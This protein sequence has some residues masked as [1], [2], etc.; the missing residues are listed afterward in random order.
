M[1]MSRLSWLYF[2]YVVDPDK[3]FQAGLSTMSPRVLQLFG[4]ADQKWFVHPAKKGWLAAP[5]GADMMAVDMN[6]HYTDCVMTAVMGWPVFGIW[7]DIEPFVSSGNDTEL[8]VGFYY[9]ETRDTTLFTGN[10]WYCEET[11]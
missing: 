4:G 11:S 3:G 9:V 10:D 7:D 6:K 8:P 1:G 2:N 5:S